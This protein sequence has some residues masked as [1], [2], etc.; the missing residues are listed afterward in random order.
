MTDTTDQPDQP[1]SA[2]RSWAVVVGGAV[3]AALAS[4]LDADT[5]PLAGAGYGATAAAGFLAWQ[6]LAP[7]LGRV[8]ALA[9]MSVASSVAFGLLGAISAV[10][11]LATTGQPG[12]G[13]VI[14]D[15]LVTG[16][17][18]PP[19]VGLLVGPPVVVARW[20]WRALA[21]WRQHRG[22]S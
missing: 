21:R 22:P 12:G 13:L 18:L 14:G 3:L 9:A 11:V 10:L 4:L 6:A 16:L 20:S 1:T 15:M 8:T 19:L 5:S 2:R 7:R 17:L